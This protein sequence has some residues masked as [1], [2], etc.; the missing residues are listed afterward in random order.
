M[1]S[2]KNMTVM[3]KPASSLCN[4]RCK[5][6]FY[7]DVSSLREVESCGIMTREVMQATIDSTLSGLVGGDSINFA[8]QG[9]EPTVAGLDYFKSFIEYVK[10]KNTKARCATPC[11]QTELCSTIIG[12]RF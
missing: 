12:A 2:I 10:S 7:A 6:C 8:F 1:S 5:Y 11:R 4:L 9:G 3:I